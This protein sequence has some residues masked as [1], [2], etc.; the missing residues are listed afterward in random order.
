MLKVYGSK[1]GNWGGWIFSRQFSNCLSCEWETWQ[2][3]E[4]HIH[5]QLCMT[6]DLYI[7]QAGKMKQ[8]WICGTHEQWKDFYIRSECS[9]LK[10][11]A[12]VSLN[13]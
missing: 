1:W 4:H 2:I 10:V 5:Q 9:I 3:S 7:T 13:K 12:L 11:Q 6:K 8:H